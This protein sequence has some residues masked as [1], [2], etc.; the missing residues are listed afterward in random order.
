MESCTTGTATF[1]DGRAVLLV[2]TVTD[3][4]A[5]KAVDQELRDLAQQ[6]DRLLQELHHRVKNN[7]QP[8]GSLL[9]LQATRTG[10][11]AP[12]DFVALAEPHILATGARHD[13]LSRGDGSGSVELASYVR[14][15][16][17]QLS[18]SYLDQGAQVRLDVDTA[19]PLLGIDR[20][21]PLG[22]VITELVTNAFRHDFAGGAFGQ[23]KV[24]MRAI[25]DGR[26]RLS[27]GD[28]GSGSARP[29]S[30]E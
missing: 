28:D 8:A 27:V 29:A 12:L 24:K 13:I 23:V 16:C 18:A 10:S 1:V 5:R 25:A 7:L 3:E 9:K 21:V 2:G 4:T 15:L 14:E 30:R 20:A 6:R 19:T 26:W 17:R 11:P 22:L